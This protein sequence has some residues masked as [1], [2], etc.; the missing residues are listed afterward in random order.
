ME[1]FPM[2]R[3]YLLNNKYPMPGF[4]AWYLASSGLSLAVFTAMGIGVWM[5]WGEPDHNLLDAFPGFVTILFGIWG[6][7][8]G[9]ASMSLWIAAWLYLLAV[10]NSSYGARAGWFLVLLFGMHYGA[11]IY[12]I[13]LWKTG[14]IKAATSHPVFSSA[15]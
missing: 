4:L 2:C 6:A 10:D 11:L 7:Y 15:K 14:R 8:T 5:I 9:I 12:A 3:S 13:Y 1:G